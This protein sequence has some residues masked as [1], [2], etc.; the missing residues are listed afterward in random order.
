MKIKDLKI[1]DHIKSTDEH[2]NSEQGYFAYNKEHEPII[3]WP[4]KSGNFYRLDD[5]EEITFVEE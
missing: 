4:G 2:G 5:T 1:G 3:L